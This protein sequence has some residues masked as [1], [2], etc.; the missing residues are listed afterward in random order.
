MHKNYKSILTDIIN[1][2]NENFNLKTHPLCCMNIHEF[3]LLNVGCHFL[4]KIGSKFYL[5]GHYLP[6]SKKFCC[7]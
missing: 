7:P 2:Q 1:S 6:K 5:K 4:F 3:C